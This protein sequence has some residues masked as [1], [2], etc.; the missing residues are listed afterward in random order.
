[1]LRLLGSPRG[2]S[3]EDPLTAFVRIV[4][5]ERSSIARL[6]T[7]RLAAELHDLDLPGKEWKE[8]QLGLIAELARLLRTRGEDAVLL[9][10]ELMRAHAIRRYEQGF[11]AEDLARETKTLQQVLLKVYSRH[12]GELEP[13][14]AD[15][16]AVLVNE[17]GAAMH[18]AYTRVIKTEEVH[19]REAAL[20]ESVLHHIDVGILLAE[21]DGELSFATPPV[22]VLLGLPPRAFIGAR[23]DGLRTLLRQ[24]RARHLDGTNV[25]AS[26][27]PLLR[28]L[29]DR[30]EVRGVTMIIEH[31]P[32]HREVI[33]EMTALPVWDADGEE[34]LGAVQTMTDRTEAIQRARAL[35]SANEE[36]RRLHGQLGERTRSEA[37]GELAHGAAHA[38]NNFLNVIRLRLTLFQREPDPRH[39][40]AL[41]RTVDKI[42]AL[43]SRLQ[44]FTFEPKAEERQ[45][46]ELFGVVREALSSIEGDLAR[47]KVEVRLDLAGDPVVLADPVSLRELVLNVV[48]TAR[49]RMPDGGRLSIHGTTSEGSAELSIED[50]G[51]AFSPEQCQGVF[52]PLKAQSPLP[53]QALLLGLG[54]TQVRR[55]DGELFCE[56]PAQGSDHGVAFRLRLPLATEAS[57]TAEQASPRVSTHPGQAARRVLIVD[58][59]P[60]NA[61]MMAE[62]LSDEGYEPTVALSGSEA[63]TCWNAAAFDAALLDA[64]MPDSSGWTL[65][66]EIRRRAPGALIAMVTGADVR[67]QNRENLALVD[68]VFRKPVDLGALDEFLSQPP[69]TKEAR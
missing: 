34:L 27:V 56:S 66:R 24:L 15:L 25:K 20:M 4:E 40:E 38:L 11:S 45:P 57:E 61:R 67:G 7:K 64:I 21:T 3:H 16:I 51:E 17:A 62:L 30:K 63:M 37:L 46:T 10:P 48:R 8:S 31:H 42:G 23:A 12:R 14:I 5:H 13:E 22:S 9:W 39:I 26:D 59:D 2:Y 49:G 41:E 32:D 50:T 53:H 35:E 19:L 44:D 58:D 1:M 54:R 6:W 60:E 18:S 36:L 33:L 65:A 52:D 47:S 29:R 68:A 28:A 69:G 43:V 55:W